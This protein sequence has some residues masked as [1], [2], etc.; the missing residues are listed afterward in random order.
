MNK[1]T[2]FN[3]H[4][5]R[6]KLKEHGFHDSGK[7]KYILNRVKSKDINQ[8]A[9]EDALEGKVILSIEDMD[10]LPSAMN[11]SR[12]SKELMDRLTVCIT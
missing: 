7:I 12:F 8:D 6:I 11:K 5:Q 1:T 3:A 9:I 10:K 4:R 2:L